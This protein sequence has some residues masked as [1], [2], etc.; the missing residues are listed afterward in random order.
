MEHSAEVGERIARAR[1]FL[2]LTQ[3]AL[4]QKV[5]VA[6]TTEVAIEQGRRPA[7]LAEL[8][9]YADVLGRPLDYFLGVGI[10]DKADFQPHFRK[11]VDSLEGGME[12]EKRSLLKFEGL[13]R[14][15]RELEEINGLSAATLPQFPS[16][17]HHS[18]LE[19]ERLAA[20]VRAHLDIGPDVPIG[21][22]RG[23]LE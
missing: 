3:A 15:Y 11:M 10:W 12:A 14:N 22:L 13:C 17:R 18:I 4:A 21:D 19:A 23:R 5:G 8:Y 6:R 9:R 7:K 2:G 1:E 16:P 20:T